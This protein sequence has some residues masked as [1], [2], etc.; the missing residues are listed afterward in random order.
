L[1]GGLTDA[2]SDLLCR[3]GGDE[4]AIC[5]TRSETDA[6]A[7]A[8]RIEDQVAVP[9]DIRGDHRRLTVS[10]G[11]AGGRRVEHRTTHASATVEDLISLASRDSTV[12]KKAKSATAVVATAGTGGR[13][14]PRRWRR[15]ALAAAAAAASFTLGV[16]EGAPVLH[17][18]R[19]L[20]RGP[21]RAAPH[22]ALPPHLS[23]PARSTADPHPAPRSAPAAAVPGYAVSIG[24][25]RTGPEAIHV[26]H[27]VRSK[28][29][30]VYVVPLGAEFEVAT[31]RLRFLIA[32]G[33]AGALEI[34]G[35]PARAV[36]LGTNGEAK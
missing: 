29:Y 34:L 12:V 10:V 20:V 18:L 24:I 32:T 14:A 13:T 7:L 28:G 8:A 35:F 17:G 1:L 11:V 36:A 25:F 26:M 5:T 33:V 9:V 16:V 23:A 21:E 15:L 3:Y 19:A 2:S 6:R 27:Q 31:S 4:F 22:V 30:V